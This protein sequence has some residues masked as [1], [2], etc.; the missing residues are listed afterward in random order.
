MLTTKVHA[1]QAHLDIA[2]ND[3]KAQL[4]NTMHRL[5]GE[6]VEELRKTLD[7]NTDILEKRIEFAAA[8]QREVALEKRVKRRK[9]Q[10]RRRD[11]S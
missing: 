1:T 10:K 5:I 4:E 9:R 3:T 6:R 2:V 7:R 11:P 8:E